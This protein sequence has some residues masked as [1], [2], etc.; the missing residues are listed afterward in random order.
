MKIHLR[1]LGVEVWEIVEK[2]YIPHD[3]N[4]GTPTP[5]DEQKRAEN[6]VRAKK[7]LLSALFDEKLLNVIELEN[8]NL[9]WTKLETL[10]EGDQAVK[11]AKREGFWVRYTNLKMEEDEKISSFMDRVNE[12]VMGIKCCGGS[13]SEDEILSKVLRVLPLAYKM[14]AIA[15]NELWTMSSTP[16]TRDTLLGKLTTFK[17]EELGDQSVAK[18]ETIFRASAFG[19]QKIDWKEMYYKDMEEIEKEERELEELEALIARRIPKGPIG[20]KYEGK[21]PFKCFSCNEIG[22]FASRCPE[23]ATRNHE[24]FVRNYMPNFEY[25][26]R[27]RFRRNKDKSCYYAGDDD[28]G[29]SDDDDE[30]MSGSGNGASS[31]KDWIFIAIKDD[32]PKS[33]IEETHTKEKDEWAIDSG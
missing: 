32:S 4:S 23:R 16:V 10:Y 17:L 25:Q 27:P 8:A 11:I 26:R 12:I 28:F 13:I 20:S 19:K 15:I 22:H 2:E 21:V 6:D 33:F 5:I 9:I 3:P 29:I 30:P 31:D 18:T 1:C 24:R 14:K 7:E